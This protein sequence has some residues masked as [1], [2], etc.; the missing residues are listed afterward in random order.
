MEKTMID[1]SKISD[2]KDKCWQLVEIL[3][4]EIISPSEYTIVLYLLSLYRNSIDL[5]VFTRND[6]TVDVELPSV[7]TTEKDKAEP[8][9]IFGRL[10]FIHN[11]F[12]PLLE[13]LSFQ[14]LGM[15]GSQMKSMDHALL[16]K[17]FGLIF[18]DLIYKINSYL[19]KL[20]GV[21]IQPLE[22]TRFA[23][24]LTSLPAN[25]KVYN[26][27][28][29]LASFSIFL[30]KDVNYLGQ[31]ISQKTW[32]LG[33]L[34]ILAHNQLNTSRFSQGNSIRHWNPW[35][36]KYDL[37]IAN[38]PFGM[39]L[40]QEI[41]GRFGSFKTCESFFIEKG[42]D[43][44]N[45][46]G[47]LIAIIPNRFLFSGGMELRLRQHIIEHDLLEMVVSFPSG[48]MPN[49]GILI[50]VVVINKD[51]KKKG[52]VRF[53]DAKNCINKTSTREKR[54]NDFELNRLVKDGKNSDSLRIVSNDSIR[55][56]GYDFSIPR[57][58]APTIEKDGQSNLV[59]LSEIVN[60]INGT[61]EIE[62]KSEKFVRIRDLKD[63]K[64][65]YL[66]DVDKLENKVFRLGQASRILNI[67]H[68]T[69]VEFLA[70]KGFILDNHPNAILTV[71]QFSMIEQHLAGTSVSLERKTIELPRQRLFSKLISESCLLLAARWQTLKPTYFKYSGEPILISQDIIALKVDESKVNIGYLINELN[72]DYVAEQAGAFRTGSVILNLRKEDLLSIRIKL[73][74]S[75]NQLQYGKSLEEQRAIVQGVLE[76]LRSDKKKELILFERI[77]G[78]ENE[79]AEQNKHLRHTLA[80]P[81]SNVIGSIDNIRKIIDSKVLDKVPE[82]MSLKLS[83]KHQQTF[84]QYLEILE[85]NVRRIAEAVSKK[86]KVENIVESKALT[87]IDIIEF[88]DS[89]ASEL[90]TR[91]SENFLIDFNYDK[92]A[93]LDDNG[94]VVK[95]FINGNADLLSDLF[96]NLVNNA[97][98]HAFTKGK[99][100]RIEIHLM[101]YDEEDL[102]ND[103]TILVSNT[104]KPFPENFTKQDFIR[105]SSAA[106]TNSG[107][108]YGGW[109]INE[110]IAYFKGNFSII[111]ETSGEGLPDSDLATSFEINFPILEAEENEAL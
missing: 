109:Y 11:V 43:D 47:K 95:T 90:S 30:G 1:N 29:G 17:H 71:E 111:D 89:Y 102:Q 51:K 67:G 64:L 45:E 52:F 92:E 53:I 46:T 48:V 10:P 72:S 3:R 19:G 85:K 9:S 7:V 28:A 106:G 62:G 101:K 73:P 36:E 23:C 91:K 49:T 107:D 12:K 24:G 58:F 94:K 61:R 82:L 93:F 4:S 42:I 38:P 60:I 80:G 104:G 70:K 35:Q 79:I 57:Y 87:P 2:L 98:E 97:V 103:I 78:L 5:H 21:D 39:R 34:R 96:D 56:S 6:K 75:H 76:A 15:L 31:E 27:F 86:L 33:S 59:L 105:K 55:D 99:M 84:G 100:E 25:A 22:L 16:D 41:T 37:I 13:S 77:H 26:P 66:L 50:S 20:G 44:L 83:E 8:R 18:D 65:D 32:A 40:P 110:I 54:I 69:I 14:T 88:L 74:V 108:G 63:D 81:S 68:N